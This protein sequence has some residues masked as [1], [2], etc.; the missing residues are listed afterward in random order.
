MVLPELKV[1]KGTQI[2]P[3]L[4]VGSDVIAPEYPGEWDFLNIGFDPQDKHGVMNF[5]HGDGSV[6]QVDLAS[7]PK[8]PSLRIYQD[9]KAAESKAVPSRSK[10]PTK[11]VQWADK[12]EN[13][14]K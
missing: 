12:K 13:H 4:I 11:T 6:K 7:W 3:L 14:G 2:D 5:I 9:T 8:R 10:K 1:I